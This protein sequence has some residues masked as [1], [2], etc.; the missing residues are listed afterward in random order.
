MFVYIRI[1]DLIGAIEQEAGEGLYE[2][3]GVWEAGF[4]E[5]CFCLWL[6][7][8]LRIDQLSNFEVPF[9]GVHAE[10]GEAFDRHLIDHFDRF[11]AVVYHLFAER[12]V[13]DEAGSEG[14]ADANLS[15]LGS[16]IHLEDRPAFIAYFLDEGEAII[17]SPLSGWGDVGA[18]EELLQDVLFVWLVFL[19]RASRAEGC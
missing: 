4:E 18:I 8:Y 6:F 3:E 10:V 2:F 1:W 19:L 13:G 7:Q 17:R 16:Q 12:E 14:G 5:G 9:L 15:L 11:G